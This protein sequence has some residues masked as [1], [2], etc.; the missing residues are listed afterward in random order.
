MQ[1]RQVCLY[2]GYP[3]QQMYARSSAEL[4]L[5]FHKVRIFSKVHEAVN[6]SI[7]FY[8]LHIWLYILDFLF[9]KGPVW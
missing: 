2:T 7:F 9:Y 3:H 4:P 6:F 1:G 8:T 5:T